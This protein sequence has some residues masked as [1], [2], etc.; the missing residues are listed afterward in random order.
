MCRINGFNFK[1]ESLALSDR[2][3]MASGLGLW[4]PFLDRGLLEFTSSIPIRYKLNLFKKKRI[5]KDAFRDKL[6]DYLFNL[7][8]KG[9]FAPGAKWLRD[10]NFYSKSKEILS[11]DYCQQTEKFFDWEYI[12]QLHLDHYEKKQ[13]NA[14]LLWA[15]LTLQL[16]V[17]K[18]NIK[19]D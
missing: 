8:K 5:L 14:N 15:L 19:I 4:V 11:A 2:M 1:D 18:F 16:W 3:S 10:D 17:K 6:P 13:Y 12:K 9:W 7:P